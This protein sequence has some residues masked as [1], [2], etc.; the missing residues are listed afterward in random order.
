MKRENVT[1]HGFRSTF[2]TWAR[3]A[4]DFPEELIQQAL[5]R[6]V[7]NMGLLNP[8]HVT[9][10]AHRR[11]LMEVWSQFLVDDAVHFGE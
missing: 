7:S 1:P 8:T 9:S 6:T 2:S 10:F 5:A 11:E 3:E 4:S